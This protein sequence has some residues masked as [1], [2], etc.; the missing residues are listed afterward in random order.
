MAIEPNAQAEWGAERLARLSRPEP[1][2]PPDRRRRKFPA[3]T[4][5]TM[6]QEWLAI[7][8]QIAAHYGLPLT[9]VV[10]WR[11]ETLRFACRELGLPTQRELAAKWGTTHPHWH[12]LV[13]MGRRAMIDRARRNRYRRRFALPVGR[14]V[15]RQEAP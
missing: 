11:G 10:G 7:L 9:V 14:P 15:G 8:Q 6:R 12:D 2:D 4:V 3:K 13:F 1:P 5:T